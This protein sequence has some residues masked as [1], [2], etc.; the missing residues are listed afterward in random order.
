MHRNVG[1]DEVVRQYQTNHIVKPMF[2]SSEKHVNIWMFV[3]PVYTENEV[4][5]VFIRTFKRNIFNGLKK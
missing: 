3:I 1:K 4:Q 2:Y 5:K